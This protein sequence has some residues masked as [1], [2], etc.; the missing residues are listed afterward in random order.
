MALACPVLGSRHA[1]QPLHWGA[2]VSH[3]LREAHTRD[4]PAPSRVK[5]PPGKHG[6]C[7]GRRGKQLRATRGCSPDDGDTPLQ[8]QSAAGL[9]EP[10]YSAAAASAAEGSSTTQRERAPEGPWAPGTPG[11]GASA[12]A[13]GQN[14]R[15]PEKWVEER[16][17]RAQIQGSFYRAESAVSRDLGALAAY[18]YRRGE[19]PHQQRVAARERER[20]ARREKRKGRDRERDGD[21]GS[22][23]EPPQSLT[24]AAFGSQEETEKSTL[25]ATQYSTHA[26]TEAAVADGTASQGLRVLDVMSGS[27]IRGVRYLE[28]AGAD[29][30]WCNDAAVDC[31][32]AL[33]HNLSAASS[34][35]PSSFPP[36]PSDSLSPSSP[37]P[38][39]QSPVTWWMPGDQ[40]VT[41]QAQA[42]SDQSQP[43]SAQSQP[44]SAQS[45]AAT[46]QSQASSAQLREEGEEAVVEGEGAVLRGDA[47]WRKARE[48]K[49]GLEG[50][51]WRITHEDALR[52][53]YLCYQVH[54]PPTTSH[55]LCL[56]LRSSQE[57]CWCLWRLL[58]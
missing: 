28:H 40:I 29:F 3:S 6:P 34:H 21:R 25:D 42:V 14:G 53:L 50:A 4:A 2:R 27:G 35:T 56:P 15:S 24:R 43:S 33:L 54:P 23:S 51:K 9:K 5:F 39:S 45:Q 38:F 55:C 7:E 37:P 30:V 57:H 44:S 16:G 46:A 19:L 47:K 49:S 31:H 10:S 13:R 41:A 20:E 26:G 12:P 11:P 18:L 22:P 52:V 17:V 32:S 36:S 1:E 8:F 58:K 48:G